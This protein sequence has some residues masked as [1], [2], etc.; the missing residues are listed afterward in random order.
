MSNAKVWDDREYVARLR[1]EWGEH[2]FRSGRHWEYLLSIAQ[3][4]RYNNVL[5][6]GCGMGHLNQIIKD[7]RIENSLPPVD[8]RGFDGSSEMIRVA[9]E[10][11]P[12]ERDRFT[13]A[14]FFDMSQ[15]GTYD[16]V[17]C[18][19]VLIH[20]RE[21]ITPMRNLWAHAN[22]ELIFTLK[23]S[24][25]P[26]GEFRELDHEL[27]IWRT[28]RLPL[29]WEDKTYIYSIIGS[30]GDVGSVEEHFF[31][32]RTSMFRV[33]RGIPKYGGFRTGWLRQ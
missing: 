26:G 21:I 25:K 14:D 31:D 23:L 5:D 3:L 22:R 20:Q 16:T 7:H 17:T 33:I 27:V 30:L 12:D 15:I 8:Y 24:E 19:D 4:I 1:L 29:R 9:H 28:E 2:N 18:T 13:V 10:F 6:A 32:M 11:Y